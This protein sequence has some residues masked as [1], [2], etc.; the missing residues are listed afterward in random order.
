MLLRELWVIYPYT[1]DLLFLVDNLNRIFLCLL[2]NISAANF[3]AL[4][5]ETI[6]LEILLK[7]SAWLYFSMLQLLIFLLKKEIHLHEGTPGYRATAALLKLIV[8]DMTFFM[9]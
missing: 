9:S 2:F 8:V 6:L 1:A 4:K 5:T 7:F 3:L